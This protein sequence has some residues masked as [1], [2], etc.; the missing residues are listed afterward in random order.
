MI[1]MIEPPDRD[2]ETL[3][4]ETRDYLNGV[5]RLSMPEERWTL[6][7]EKLKEVT[8]H[9]EWTALDVESFIKQGRCS[10]HN[11]KKSFSGAAAH[12]ALSLEDIVKLNRYAMKILEPVFQIMKDY[13]IS[14]DFPPQLTV[15][16]GPADL[17]FD[18]EISGAN[19]LIHDR[20][21][22]TRML[23]IMTSYTRQYLQ[24]RA[25]GKG[26]TPVPDT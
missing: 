26:P 21:Y 22:Q 20:A 2:Y 25:E 3:I 13:I 9:L 6:M 7:A 14:P 5:A 8:P 19:A 12:Q 4:T 11:L 18:F 17:S 23:E 24:D 10:F 1:E 15:K 16:G